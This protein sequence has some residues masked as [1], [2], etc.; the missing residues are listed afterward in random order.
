MS[1]FDTLRQH[2]KAQGGT[3]I[4]HL[5]AQD[6]TRFQRL[7]P[8]LDDILFN[9]SKTALDAAARGGLLALPPARGIASALDPHTAAVPY[10]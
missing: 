7:S 1:A 3:R 10:H 2:R 4:A 9:Y 5:F 6:P 8:L